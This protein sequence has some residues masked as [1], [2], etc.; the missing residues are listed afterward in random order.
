MTALCRVGAPVQFGRSSLI[1]VKVNT[2]CNCAAGDGIGLEVDLGQDWL[3]D[4]EEDVADDGSE[5][6]SSSGNDAA[7]EDELNPDDMDVDMLEAAD[8]QQ[9]P[10]Q[11]AAGAA[12]VGRRQRRKAAANSTQAAGAGDGNAQPAAVKHLLAQE[13][14]YVSAAW[15]AAALPVRRGHRAVVGGQQAT[16]LPSVWSA[17][18][19]AVAAMQWFCWWLGPDL[20]LRLGL[21]SSALCGCCCSCLLLQADFVSRSMWDGRVTRGMTRQELAVLKAPLVYAEIMS[22]I[23]VRTGRGVLGSNFCCL[24]HWGCNVVQVANPV[25]CGPQHGTQRVGNGPFD[26]NR[27]Y[28]P[29]ARHH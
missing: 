20:S 28:G 1:P 2:L 14:T 26:W 5:G 22:F 3:E 17:C 21:Q 27:S 23:K 7:A 6:S 12:E 13:V 10:Q 4:D 18:D 19:C 9:Q 25:S 24:L 16:A 8:E 29:A 11:L 15:L